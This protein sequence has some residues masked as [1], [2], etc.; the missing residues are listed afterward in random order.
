M[1]SSA[2]GSAWGERPADRSPSPDRTVTDAGDGGDQQRMT[3]LDLGRRQEPSLGDHGPDRRGLRIA[4]QLGQLATHIRQVD[5]VVGS[6]QA[7]VHHRHQALAAGDDLHLV[8]A[9]D[10]RAEQGDGVVD[11]GWSV[12]RERGRFHGPERSCVPP[13]PSPAP[14]RRGPHERH[15]PSLGRH[16]PPTRRPHRA[17]H[18]RRAGRGPQDRRGVRVRRCGGRLRLQ[19]L[20]R[21]GG[22]LRRA[23]QSPPA[24]GRWPSRPI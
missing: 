6:G 24:V 14:A 12:Q 8:A 5:E 11:V 19:H 18:R 9:G 21:R 2:A 16:G 22:P 7:E 17:R 15:P 4:H 20:G 13:R 23:T 1:Q 3:L 10:Q